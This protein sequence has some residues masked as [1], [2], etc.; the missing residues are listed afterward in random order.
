MILLPQKE[1]IVERQSPAPGRPAKT[2]AWIALLG[3]L[4]CASG[5]GVGA[6]SVLDEACPQDVVATSETDYAGELEALQKLLDR[7]GRRVGSAD[8]QIIRTSDRPALRNRSTVAGAMPALYPADLLHAGIS[9][10][11]DL[12]VLI[13]ENGRVESTMV[14]KSAGAAPFDQAS[15]TVSE[16][17]QFS[18]VVVNGCRAAYLHELPVVWRVTGGRYPS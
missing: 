3:T 5:T 12:W 15:T 11:T 6:T 17:M 7:A 4:A 13:G 18:P 1:C 14:R 9:G 8:L 2:G 10:Q 16:L